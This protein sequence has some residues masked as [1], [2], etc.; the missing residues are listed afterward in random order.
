MDLDDLIPP[1]RYEVV[2]EKV[3]RGGYPTLRNF[4]FL[5]RLRLVSVLSLVP[6]PPTTDLEDYVNVMNLKI[7]HIP[8]DRHSLITNEDVISK[9]IQALKVILHYFS[10][11]SSSFISPPML[12]RYVQI[13]VTFPSISTAW[14]ANA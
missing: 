2:T 11:S 8:M 12:S 3:Y 5:N 6:E 14:M 13:K 10:K 1:L 9:F 4:R 7:I